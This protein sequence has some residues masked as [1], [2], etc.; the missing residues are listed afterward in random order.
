MFVTYKML[1]QAGAC[2]EELNRF[3]ALFPHG[4]EITLELCLEHGREFD[5]AWFANNVFSPE[6]RRAYD[7]AFDD[8]EH[9]FNEAIAMAFFEASQK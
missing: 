2:A 3:Q 7:R 1:R 4:T 8:A 5:L 6:Q 9:V